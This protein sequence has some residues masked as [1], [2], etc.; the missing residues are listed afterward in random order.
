M[1]GKAKKFIPCIFEPLTY[2][3]AMTLTEIYGVLLK[4][5]RIS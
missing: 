1:N 5:D 2:I 4:H 3:V